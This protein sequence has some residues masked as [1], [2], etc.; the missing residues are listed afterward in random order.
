MSRPPQ[1]TKMYI[2][3]AITIII[4]V[5]FGILSIKNAVKKNEPTQKEIAYSQQWQKISDSISKLFTNPSRLKDSLLQSASST[6]NQLQ[7]PLKL[8]ADQLD[9]ITDKLQTSASTS[10]ADWLTYTNEEYGFEF[11]YPKDWFINNNHLSPQPIEYYAIGSN[12]API[13]FGIYAKNKEIFLDSSEIGNF[14][15]YEYQIKNSKRN[16]SDS[17]LDING[18]IFQ[19]YDLIDYG[20]YEGDS[21][22]NVILLVGP[23]LD[24]QDLFVVFEWQQF[25]VG[26]ELKLNKSQDFINIISTFKFLD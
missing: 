13:S 21:A 18:I 25:P 8:T 7:N 10:T 5:V 2:Y 26:K 3:L 15:F 20:R 9:Q 23:P 16:N 22:G 19:Y 11:K 14:G 1:K 17:T 12:N 6:G 24:N 4:V